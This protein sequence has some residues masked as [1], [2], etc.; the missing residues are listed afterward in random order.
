MP[1]DAKE[2]Y[3]EVRN[4]QKSTRGRQV[5]RRR[6]DIKY[7]IAGLLSAIIFI[8]YYPA[9]WNDFVDWDDPDYVLS[10]PHIH[11]LSLSFLK[12]AFSS[13]YASNW[14]PLTWISHALDYA[15]WGLNPMGHHL[16]NNVLH[17]IN[18]FLV[19]L[20]VVRLMETWKTRTSPHLNVRGGQERLQGK[21][22]GS[23]DIG[24]LIT[25][26]TTGLLFG[27]HPCI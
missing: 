23:R 25:A 14:H 7:L 4:K 19:V 27:L 6:P 26:G 20:L 3:P 12:W 5:M 21:K 15:V 16:T 18:T 2:T 17:A 13:F 8:C 1:A 24:V 10:N 22:E 11:S 9:L